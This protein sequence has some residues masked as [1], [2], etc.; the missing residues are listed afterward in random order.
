M[1]RLVAVGC[2][3]AGALMPFGDGGMLLGALPA[4]AP[5]GWLLQGAGL[6]AILLA[7]ILALHG[8]IPKHIG[9]VPAP[10][11]RTLALLALLGLSMLLGA[12][13]AG[14]STPLDPLH[15][16]LLG[17]PGMVFLVTLGAGLLRVSRED[18]D[19]ARI[20]IVGSSMILLGFLITPHYAHAI[21]RTPGIA[22]LSGSLLD[23][24]AVF[25]M[26]ASASLGV[27]GLFRR[28]PRTLLRITGLLALFYPVLWLL[29]TNAPLAGALTAAGLTLALTLALDTSLQESAHPL[30]WKRGMEWAALIVIFGLF[31][32]LKTHGMRASATDENIY[33]YDGW[34]MTR[35]LLPYRDFFFAHPPVHLLFPAAWI[36]AFGFDVIA[37]KTLAP[38]ATLIT[39]VFVH[40]IGREHIGVAGGI[41][42][43]LLFLFASETLKA[44]T[45]LTGVNLTGMFIT[46]GLWAVLR[47]REGLGGALFALAAS[48]GFY[49]MA[50]FMAV[51]VLLPWRGRSAFSRFALGFGVVFGGIAL[52][53][54]GIGGEAYLDQVY[55]YHGLKPDKFDR[56]PVLGPEGGGLSAIHHN[57]FVAF[58]SSRE[59][60]RNIYYHGTLFWLGAMTPVVAAISAW[61]HGAAGARWRRFHPKNLWD[62]TG[63]GAALLFWLVA[64]AYFL[65]L[66]LFKELHDYYITLPFSA[67]A[68]AG[69]WSVVTIARLVTQSIHS[70]PSR[71]PS[72][73]VGVAAALVIVV[74]CLGIGPMRAKANRTAFPG[75]VLKNGQ[76]VTYTYIEPPVLASLS[77]VIRTLFWRGERKRGSLQPGYAHYLWSKKPHF[78]SAE[79]IASRVAETTGPEDTIAGASTMAPLIA[80]LANRRIAADEVDTNSKRFKAKMLDWNTYAHRI[81]H[82]RVSWIIGTHRSYFTK[83]HLG[84]R[85]LIDRHFVREETVVDETLRNHGSRRI[86]LY[87]RTS[88]PT[89]PCR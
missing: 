64:L 56:L 49:A 4:D 80:L 84:R 21:P 47:E 30:G 22:L 73:A 12:P 45:N 87:R 54:W 83:T 75:E 8:R 48:T 39:G 66:S 2:L 32:L 19:P 61:A 76:A 31:I 71:R 29:F 1:M 33:F 11:A 3:L 69:A 58:F 70:D 7:A 16:D 24:S 68:I 52:V 72:S 60:L 41:L 51:L 59:F 9:P 50:G 10:G 55:R 13:Q 27:F 40:R 23:K 42:A 6:A 89:I 5:H 36:G 65:Q 57:L 86:D 62:H 28:P 67:L 18:T 26:T 17:V 79:A 74:T 81:C 44:S 46:A 77:P 34:L 20:L 25:L 43:P 35:G 14:L 88:D 63:G 53:S 85:S 37:L 82:D 38:L 15:H 78:G